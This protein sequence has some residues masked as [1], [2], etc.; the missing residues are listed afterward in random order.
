MKE[1]FQVFLKIDFV[2]PGFDWFRFAG[3]LQEN[4]FLSC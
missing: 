3:F 1:L 4:M 2:L